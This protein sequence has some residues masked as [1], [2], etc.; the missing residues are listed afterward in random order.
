[1]KAQMVLQTDAFLKAITSLTA[2]QGAAGA[3][4]W[5]SGTRRSPGRADGP[6][7]TGIVPDHAGA[8]LQKVQG[9]EEHSTKRVPDGARS[10]TNQ[11]QVGAQYVAAFCQILPEGQGCFMVGRL[12]LVIGG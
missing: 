2:N 7:H 9:W 4:D 1:M 10:K 8:L 3:V 12:H 11:T 5:T 6:K